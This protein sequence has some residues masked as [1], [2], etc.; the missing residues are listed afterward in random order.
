MRHEPYDVATLLRS[1]DP[2]AP[3]ASDPAMHQR[4][5]ARLP[6]HQTAPGPTSASPRRSRRLRRGAVLVA[7][8]AA[9]ITAVTLT[10]TQPAPAM[11]ALTPEAKASAGATAE[12]AGDT[13]AERTSCL[14]EFGDG[15]ADDPSATYLLEERRGDLTSMIAAYG[16]QTAFCIIGPDDTGLLNSMSGLDVDVTDRPTTGITAAVSGDDLDGPPESRLHYLT[17][18]YGPDVHG[19]DLTLADGRQLIASLQDGWFTAWWTGTAT[20]PDA[21]V[22]WTTTDGTSATTPYADVPF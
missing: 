22:T 15:I 13:T 4:V 1:V 14:R 9:G 12:P 11:A 6:L 10:V 2:G 5:R 21:Q 20:T 18:R 17:G 3:Q 19:I 16:D 8:A 7:A